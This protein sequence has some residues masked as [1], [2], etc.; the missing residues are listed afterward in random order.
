MQFINSIFGY[1]LGWVMWLCYKIIP[2]YGVALILFTIITRAILVPLSIKQQ[3]SMVKMAIFRPRMEEIQKKYANNREKMNEELMKLYEEE[4]YNP[5]SGCL[6]ML[7][8]F[9]ILF[10]LIDVIY[11]PLTHILRLGT[12]LI[13]PATEIAKT[14]LGGTLNSYSV[15]LNIIDAVN[16]NPDAFVSLPGFAEKVSS[17]NLMLGPIDLTQQPTF[18]FNL[19][20]LIPILSGLTSLFLSILTMKQSSATAGDN[21][22]AAGMSK[23]MM[24][25]MPIFSTFFAFQVPAGVGIYWIMSNVLMAVQT[26]LLNKFMNPQEM[27][28]KAKAEYEARK[29]QQ[30][31]EKIEAKKRAKAG[32][33][34]AIKKAMSAKEINRIKLAEARKR[35]AEKYGEEYKEV[36]DEDFK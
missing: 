2:V 7:I 3:K 19:L 13:E 28:E 1:P 5:M 30:R 26:F 10:G 18:A 24:L 33:A 27:A 12:E 16:Q 17:M 31:Q 23:S 9:P 21:A 35:D 25:F 20:L 32:E 8:Q 14:V 11:R 15:Q 34:D 22:A 4:H 29:E 36:T 6:P